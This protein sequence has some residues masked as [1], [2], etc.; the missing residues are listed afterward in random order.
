MFV[1]QGISEEELPSGNK[2]RNSP[3]FQRSI[4]YGQHVIE[5]HVWRSP[6]ACTFATFIYEK[7]TERLLRHFTGTDENEVIR[8]ALEWCE[9]N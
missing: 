7:G 9:A 5:M 2:V 6:D 3:S 4:N 8:Q 1:C